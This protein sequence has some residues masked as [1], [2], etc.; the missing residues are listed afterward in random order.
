MPHRNYQALL[1]FTPLGNYFSYV[2]ETTYS[3]FIFDVDI[4]FILNKTFHC[5]EL[6]ISSCNMQGGLLIYIE[7]NEKMALATFHSDCTVEN[8][9]KTVFLIGL[10]ELII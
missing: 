10:L 9:H 7:K 3:I 6:A 4:S 1:H 5:V 8:F 2:G